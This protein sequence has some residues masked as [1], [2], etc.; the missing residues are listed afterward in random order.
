MKLA[1]S[2]F[3]DPHRLTHTARSPRRPHSFTASP[4]RA[5]ALLC[6][7]VV[8]HVAAFSAL[9]R[10]MSFTVKATPTPSFVMVFI[11]PKIRDGGADAA[12]PD[13]SDLLLRMESSV[14]Q[15]QIDQ[16]AIEVEATRNAGASVAAPTLIGSAPLDM[17]AYTRQAA[18]LPGEGATVVLRIEVLASG[19]A[20]RIEIDTSS[21]SHQVDEAA[22]TYARTRHWN[23]GRMNGAAQGM[24]I[25]WGV[26]L[27]A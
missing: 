15:L 16:P 20:G 6:L 10:S 24:W 9:R 11:Q 2:L 19:E 8:V 1:H 27:Q 22:I 25:R 5:L 7:V 4:A 13:M 3:W 26:R 21:G 17:S 14:T 23:A 12:Q 18:L